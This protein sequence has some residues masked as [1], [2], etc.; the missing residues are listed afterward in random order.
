MTLNTWN[1]MF[2][3]VE[4]GVS[5]LTDAELNT[6]WHRLAD[7]NWESPMDKAQRG[8]FSEKQNKAIQS[9]YW[10]VSGEQDERY[11]IAEEPRI[12]EF[13]NSNFAGKTWE[14]IKSNEESYDNW[15][16]YSDWHKD[17][18]GYRPHGVVCGQYV[19]PW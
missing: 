15:G 16:F 19:R 14:E 12:R 7:G 13:F 1:D 4:T 11:R 3:L 9:L 5:D 18:F 6:I 17:V 2:A 10:M 8:E